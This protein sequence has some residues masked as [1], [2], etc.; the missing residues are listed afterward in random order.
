MEFQFEFGL[1]VIEFRLSSKSKNFLSILNLC[2]NQKQLC[3]HCLMHCITSMQ[4]KSNQA[5]GIALKINK[6]I[7][8]HLVL[9][10]NCHLK[11]CIKKFTFLVETST[12]QK[13]A[14]FLEFDFSALV[15]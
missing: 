8:D 3:L 11:V 13:N 12:G 10:K 6:N 4:L 5:N 2:K 14:V 9:L 7:R 1:F 15:I